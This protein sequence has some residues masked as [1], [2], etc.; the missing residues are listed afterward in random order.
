MR[1]PQNDLGLTQPEK[2][3]DVFANMLGRGRS[4]RH[5]RRT[6]ERTK[7]FTQL[8]VRRPEVVAPFGDT[9]RFVDRGRADTRL[10]ENLGRFLRTESFRGRHHQQVA[11]FA[12]PFELFA[13]LLAPDGT[14]QSDTRNVAL[15]KLFVL[16]AQQGE[17]GGDQDHRLAHRHRRDLITGRLA[18]PRRQHHQNVAPLAHMRDHLFLLRVQTVDP[19]STRRLVDLGHRSVGGLAVAATRPR[20]STPAAAT[21]AAALLLRP[22][23]LRLGR[24][25]SARLLRLTH[26]L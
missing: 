10:L 6:A 12:N 1:R 23:R 9:V 19:E 18:E 22:R 8:Q 20:T 2:P 14:V 17:Q 7:P 25:L 4:E 11:A 13:P 16:V 5:D 21:V 3:H 26:R 24:L 15:Q